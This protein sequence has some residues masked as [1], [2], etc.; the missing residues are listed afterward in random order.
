MQML[1]ALPAFLACVGHDAEALLGN[2]QLP[3]KLRYHLY[4]YMA[5]QLAVLSGQLQEA[6]NVLFRDD[7]HMLGSLRLQITESNYLIILID[8]IRRNLF[9]SYLAKDTICHQYTPRFH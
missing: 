7:Q 5:R 3:G 9:L 1:H 8:D 4:Q 6:A 2:A